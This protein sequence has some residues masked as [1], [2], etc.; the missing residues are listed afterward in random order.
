MF[1]CE[2]VG[3]DYLI[4]FRLSEDYAVKCWNESHSS[5]SFSLGLIGLI[6][7]GFFFPFYLLVKLIKLNKRNKLKNMNVRFKF[8]YFYYAFKDK[9]YYWDII[10]LVRR[11][12]LMFFSIYFFNDIKNRQ[13]FPICIILGLLIIALFIHN[14][15]MPYNIQK[16]KDV[17]YLEETSLITLSITGIFWI[18]YFKSVI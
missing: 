6:F 2:N 13:L 9:F 18:D 16:F 14:E 15:A 1:K 17:N 7:F 3:D 4:V 10:I 5:W 11:F 8:G 12:F